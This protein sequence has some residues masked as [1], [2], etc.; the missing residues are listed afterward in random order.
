VC[1]AGAVG[2]VLEETLKFEPKSARAEVED[3]DEDDEEAADDERE[4]VLDDK[5]EETGA[6]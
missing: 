6:A 1:E 5:V 2:A 3:E 4:L